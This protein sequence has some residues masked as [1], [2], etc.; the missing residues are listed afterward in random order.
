LNQNNIEERQS[1]LNSE[2]TP[3]Q[4]SRRATFKQ[5]FLPPVS[6]IA[7]QSYAAQ[8]E[9]SSQHFKKKPAFAGSLGLI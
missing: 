3:S 9:T 7:P 8:A 4:T 2:C 5:M 1:T 6:D